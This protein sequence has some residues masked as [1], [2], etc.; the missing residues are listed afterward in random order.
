MPRLERSKLRRALVG[1]AGEHYV[2]FRLYQQGILSSLAP[3]GTAKVDVL[4]LSTDERVVATLQVKTR[5]YGAVRGWHMSP[6]HEAI[7]DDRAF[8]AFVDLEPVPHV[9]YV[10]PS[11]VVAEIVRMSHQAWLAAPGVKGQAHRDSA[12]RRVK[13][14]YNP[15][16]PGYG[17]EWLDQCRENWQLLRGAV[18]A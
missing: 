7:V 10:V 12:V 4:V 3:P 17:P 16:V 2:L 11:R 6:K 18:G 1:P 15:P 8:Y 9:R 5:T 13:P 14:T